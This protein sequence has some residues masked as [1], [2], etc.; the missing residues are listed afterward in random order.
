MSAASERSLPPA[1]QS[2]RLTDI[3]ASRLGRTCQCTLVSWWGRRQLDGTGLVDYGRRQSIPQELWG[4]CIRLYG[5][6]HGYRAIADRLIP[7]GVSTTKSSVERLIKGLPPY[8]G[9]RVQV[10]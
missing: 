7:L 10:I 5:Q 2:N 3:C 1:D 9:C 6:G 4:E 8:Q